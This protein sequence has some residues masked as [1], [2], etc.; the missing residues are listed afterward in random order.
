MPF[1][2]TQLN[3]HLQELAKRYAAEL[4]RTLGDRLVSVV[5]FGSVARGEAG[6]TSDID[7]F[8]VL[9][10]APRDMTKRRALLEPAR[11]ALTPELERLWRQDIFADFVEIIRTKAEARQFHPVYLDMT[12]EAVLLYDRDNF[13]ANILKQ[14]KQ[15]LKALGA[16]RKRLGR[17]WYWDLKPDFKPGEVIEL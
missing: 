4:R 11:Q 15:R 7:L 9:D 8:V 10:D 17:K 2:R 13:M 5:L 1:T 3:A 14:L 12:E 6:P 16:Q